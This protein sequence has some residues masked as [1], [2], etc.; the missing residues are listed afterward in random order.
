[1][2]ALGFKRILEIGELKNELGILEV[3]IPEPEP[4]QLQIQV[5]ASCI[6]IDDIHAAEGTFLG[7][8][9]PFKASE[10]HFL[11]PGKLSHKIFILCFI[12]GAVKIITRTGIITGSL[13]DYVPV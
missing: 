13:K 2:K 10:R 8:F 3:P 6:N 12:H 1:M 9:L 4:N 7:G 11:R 5:H